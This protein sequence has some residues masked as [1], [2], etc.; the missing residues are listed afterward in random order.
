MAAYAAWMTLLVLAYYGLPGMRV[1]VWGLLALSGVAA[2]VVGVI[3]NRPARRAPWLLLAAANLSF[4]AGQLSFL[5]AAQ[6][7]HQ[8]LPFPSFADVL[9]LATY[10]L[11]AAGLLIF[12][13]RRTPDREPAQPD[14]RADPDRGPGPAV[15]DVPDPALRAQPAAV[16][17]A[18]ERRHR[19]PARRRAGAGHAGPAARAG[20]GGGSGPSSCSPS[21]R[22]ACWP[23]TW[24][25]ARSSCTARSTSARSTDLGW[26]VFYAAWGAAALHP[27]MAELTEPV[28]R[29]QAPSSAGPAHPAHAGLADRP[30][31]T[32]RR[33]RR[34]RVHDAGVIAV[35]SALLYML[36]L[37][38]LADVA[39]A[40]RRTLARSP[41]PAAGRGGP[42]GRGH[43]GAGRQRGPVRGGLT[44]WAPAA[45]DG[46]ARRARR[47]HPA[48][49]G[50]PPDEPPVPDG[51]ARRPGATAG[52]RC[53]NG[54]EPT[55]LAGQRGDRVERPALP[56][57]CRTGR[58]VIP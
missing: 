40:H 50:A 42:G 4:A 57:P 53:S 23:P 26:A 9:Y 15:V 51:A 54:P 44:D 3:L 27:T 25:S 47:Q 7:R 18:E 12:I 19:L 2:I 20:A 41:G 10:P 49:V 37:S 22:S 36:V 14:R 17:A 55:L 30:G 33:G 24:P 48:A 38:R 1:A 5:V 52:S 45:H 21:A 32:V 8:A 39:A 46:R 58:P 16:L 31:G 6:V 34:H 28:T 29:P 13:R 11:Y 56:L 35:F 43:G